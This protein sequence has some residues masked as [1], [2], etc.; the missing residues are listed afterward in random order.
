[1]RRRLPSLL[2][3]VAAALP[4][5]AHAAEWEVSRDDRVCTA[6][7]TLTARGASDQT[8]DFRTDGERLR[9][10]IRPPAD[11]ELRWLQ[12][13][14][15]RFSPPLRA[16]DGALEGVV[17]A[18]LASALAKGRRL[19]LAWSRGRP[20]TGSL[21]GSAAGLERLRDCGEELRL[22]RTGVLQP[23]NLAQIG[24]FEPGAGSTSF[25]QAALAEARARYQRE[26]MATMG[27]GVLG[28]GQVAPPNRTY[29]FEGAEP[30]VCSATL[31][32]FDCR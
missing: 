19:T 6:R 15:R 26:V 20:V 5:A 7:M 4:G 14:S 28:A 13:G 29:T 10:R 24:A 27:A 3:I 25:R 12:I 11:A 30:I 1:M 8:L 23:E 21:T 2:L 22:A 17:D 16:A 32:S 31:E 18:A 9:M